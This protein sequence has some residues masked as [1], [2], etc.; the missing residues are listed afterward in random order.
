MARIKVKE[1]K[2]DKVVLTMSKKEAQ[3]LYLSIKTDQVREFTWVTDVSKKE[4][5]AIRL[6]EL[7]NDM[8]NDLG[9]DSW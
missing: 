2:S 8:L 4:G 7:L 3:A 6:E 9:V 1:T 5:L